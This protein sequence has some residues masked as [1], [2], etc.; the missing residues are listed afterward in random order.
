MVGLS[1][2]IALISKNYI[3]YWLINQKQ[4]ELQNGLSVVTLLIGLIFSILF[5]G[6]NTI[7][8]KKRITQLAG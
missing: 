7:S 6:I 3:N 5:I 8:T 2:I 4:I 1:F